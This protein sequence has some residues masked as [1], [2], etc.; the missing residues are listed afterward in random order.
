M[1]LMQEPE[2]DAD[3]TAGFGG[4]LALQVAGLVLAAGVAV[5][6]WTLGS[7]WLSRRPDTQLQPAL[8]YRRDAVSDL[9]REQELV[10][11]RRVEPESAP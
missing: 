8:T 3:L 11:P 5:L 7:D 10:S 1:R 2:A 6:L 4:V 9:A